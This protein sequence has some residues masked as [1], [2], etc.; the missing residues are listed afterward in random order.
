MIGYG[1][2]RLTSCKSLSEAQSLV[3]HVI[4]AGI[5]Y[6]DTAPSYGRGYSEKILGTCLQH[7]G[8]R[9]ED[10]IIATK[11][12]G[13][14]QKNSKIPIALALAFKE[15]QRRLRNTR[16]NKLLLDT[17]AQASAQSGPISSYEVNIDDV[18]ASVHRSLKLLKT[19]YIDILLLHEAL[20]SFLTNDALEYVKD[21]KKSGLA[22]QIGIAANGCN[23]ESLCEEDIHEWDILQYEYGPAWPSHYSFR[24]KFPSKQHVLH[25]CVGHRYNYDLNPI[26][27]LKSVI[28]EFPEATVLFSSLNKQHISANAA[29]V[30]SSTP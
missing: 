4:S 24:N 20:P 8:L 14:A 29:I 7:S 19:D 30:K 28:K 6:F 15:L 18:K 5:R 25:S 3:K 12:G 17:S 22:K 10:L 1:C 21:L 13:F 26:D 9:R 11:L 23:Y 16:P 27:C 2:V